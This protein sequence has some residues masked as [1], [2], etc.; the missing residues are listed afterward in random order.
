MRFQTNRN[1]SVNATAFVLLFA[2]VLEFSMTLRILD[3]LM[4]HIW[5][6][7][8]IHYPEEGTGLIL[9]T[10]NGDSRQAQILLPLTNHVHVESRRNRYLIDSKDIL[11]VEQE[12]ESMGLDV[13]GVF[14]SHPDHPPRP[15][16]Y[17]LQWA[18]PCYSYLITSVHLGKALESRSWRL[19]EDRSRFIEEQLQVVQP[20][21]TEG[22]QWK[23]VRVSSPLRSH[24]NGLKE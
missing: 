20:K 8:E 24:T 19:A 5:E 7:G 3:Q 12:A 2:F 21:L 11:A 22:D 10:T 14:H 4:Q 15:S 16:E 23:V 1:R 18:L 17:D 13:I 6:H 9:G